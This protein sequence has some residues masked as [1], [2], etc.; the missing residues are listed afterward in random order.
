M[1][2]RCRAASEGRAALALA[3][4]PARR[5]SSSSVSDS[6]RHPRR[7]GVSI[8]RNRRRSHMR[9]WSAWLRVCSLHTRHLQAHHVFPYPQ[10]D[11]SSTRRKFSL[12]LATTL[13]PP[14]LLSAQTRWPARRR[15]SPGGGRRSLRARTHR[16]ACRNPP[17]Y[18]DVLDQLVRPAV[19]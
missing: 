4:S 14:P 2:Q 8:A 5:C 13:L 6:C 17:V 16:S 9:P 7:S 3:S 12:N 11:T 15:R 10:L 1:Y 19:V 18:G